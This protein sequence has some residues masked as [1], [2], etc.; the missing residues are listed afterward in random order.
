MVSQKKSSRGGRGGVC[1]PMHVGE[2]RSVRDQMSTSLLGRPSSPLYGDK[3]SGS[4]PSRLQV[5]AN[6]N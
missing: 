3:I 4:D 5:I 2:M 6:P 1:K